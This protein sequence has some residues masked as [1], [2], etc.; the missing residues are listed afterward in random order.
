M[1][2]SEAPPVVWATG[3]TLLAGTFPAHWVDAIDTWRFS[4]SKIAW[5]VFLDCS[6]YILSNFT[7]Q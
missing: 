5:F 1:K 3:N 2:F 6:F 4:Q 7:P